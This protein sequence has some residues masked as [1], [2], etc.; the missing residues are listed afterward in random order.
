[1]ASRVLVS[2][3]VKATTER[4]FEAFTRE[5]ADW[6]Q[7]NGLFEFTRQ[8]TGALAFEPRQG[9]RLTMAL[10]NGELFEV[11]RIQVWE[12]P[13]RLIFSWR[14]ERFRPDQSTEVRVSFEPIGEETRVTVEH[15]GWDAIPQKHAARHGLPLHVF[16]LRLGE[17]WQALLRSFSTRSQRAAQQ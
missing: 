13:L 16:Q 9:G 10:A 14:T 4:A 6:W 15:L 5:I 1:M 12:P 7:P 17:A 8:D 2:L 11:G 3:R